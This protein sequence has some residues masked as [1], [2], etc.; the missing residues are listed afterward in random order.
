[1]H[2]TIQR[3]Q[4]DFILTNPT[5]RE[6][7]KFSVR[8]H[9]LDD[10]WLSTSDHAPTECVVEDLPSPLEIEASAPTL[11]GWQPRDESAI[12]EYIHLTNDI[13]SDPTTSLANLEDRIL[14]AASTV[15]HTTAASRQNLE[16]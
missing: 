12:H 5:V 10:P 16:Q 4:I 11:R 9:V 6:G 1:M 13:L 7:C 15:P 8:T 2:T 3:S 14:R